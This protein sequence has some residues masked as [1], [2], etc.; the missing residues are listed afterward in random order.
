MGIKS[1]I[2][3][4]AGEFGQLIYHLLIN[5]GFYV[6]YFIDDNKD[7]HETFLFG[8]KIFSRKIISTDLKKSDLI[9]VAIRS[10]NE[11]KLQ[12]LE[13]KKWLLNFH[14]NFFFLPDFKFFLKKGLSLKESLPKDYDIFLNRNT[15]LSSYPKQEKFFF[16][17]T[18]LITGAAGSIGSQLLSHIERF[19][20]KKIIGIDKNEEGI[21]WLKMKSKKSELKLIDCKFYQDLKAIFEKN[22]IDI[23][24]NAA[25]YKHVPLFEENLESCW[26]NNLLIVENL[27]KLSNEYGVKNFLQVSSDKAVNPTNAMGA[28]KR[29]AELYLLSIFKKKKCNLTITRFG[30]VLGSSGSVIKIFE[31]QIEDDNPITVTDSEITRYFMSINEAVVLL[32]ESMIYTKSQGLFVL[33]MGEPVKI[34]D[35]AKEFLI[36]KNIK[37]KIGENIIITGLREGEKMFEEILLPDEL[38]ISSEN[39]KIFI[40]ENL[41][42]ENDFLKKYNDFK[43][44]PVTKQN[45]NKLIKEYYYE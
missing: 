18:I 36:S 12:L 5:D 35:L 7:L 40:V 39:D 28:S 9:I 21:F 1:V 8:K 25:A 30:N 17:K 23:V 24:I 37:P 19:D 43:N 10:R 41:D 3:F 15:H 6:K 45:I 14:E 16:N 32:S 34:I 29:V 22:Q 11:N 27:S 31:K 33:N 2:I 20:T 4:G 42:I 38:K 13:I 44:T 26:N